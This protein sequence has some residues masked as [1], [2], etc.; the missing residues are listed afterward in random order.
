MYAQELT[1][2]ND[3]LAQSVV[4]LEAFAQIARAVGGQTDLEPVLSVILAQ[5]R[6]IVRARAML[7]CVPDGDEL[8]ALA[9]VAEHED[10]S[11]RLPLEGSLA[12]EVVRDGRPLRV[13][14]Q[15]EP[16][17]LDE[18]LPGA[19]SG[20]L[21]AM[22]FRGQPLG[23]LAAVDPLDG[24]IFSDDDEL[25][26]L[27]IAASAATAVATARSVA[28]ERLRLSLEAAEQARGRW[29]R[30]LHD[31]TLQGLSGVRMVLAA[32]LARGD[33]ETLR[34]AATSTDVHLAAELQR[35]RDLI[36]E[37]R[38]AA[39]D[40]LGL[41]PAIET[42]AK[43]QA[44]AGGFAIS[45]DVRLDA[46]ERLERELESSIYRLVQEALTNVA[47][48]ADARHAGVSVSRCADHVEVSVQD[49]GC[50]FD[51]AAASSGFGLIGMRE[52]AMLAGGRLLVSSQAGGP[53]RVSVVLPV[54]VTAATLVMS[55]SRPGPAS[56]AA[57]PR[58][59]AAR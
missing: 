15:S 57:S 37:L 25:L 54:P 46:G 12:G 14:A 52:R 18:L 49:D 24:H 20:L 47:K 45:C 3:H 7:V 16:Q 38:P 27:S 2:A 41:G 26:L 32:G 4:R 23:V 22:M 55:G 58:T 31:E 6:E 33:L 56:A 13:D 10:A 21:V 28:A 48:H 19:Q 8:R 43:R 53:T 51:P 39:L 30:E 44:A 9:G 17:R 40:D 59:T 35:L 34:R 42:L 1:D 36:T 29:A 50:G 5:G 11:V